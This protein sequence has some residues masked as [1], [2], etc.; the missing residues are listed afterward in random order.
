MIIYAL[1]ARGSLILAEY[2]TFEGSFT[3]LAQRIIAQ[4]KPSKS[5][6]VIVKEGCS[7]TFFSEDDFTFLCLTKFNVPKDITYRFLDQLAELFFSNHAKFEQNSTIKSF[8]TQFSKIIQEL[9][10]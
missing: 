5:K 10:V 8:G 1:V 4:S 7:F 9:I 6:K 2:S 3:T